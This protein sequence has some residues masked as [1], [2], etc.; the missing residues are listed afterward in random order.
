MKDTPY[1]WTEVEMEIE[2]WKEIRKLQNADPE[3]PLLVHIAS[4]ISRYRNSYQTQME[5][6]TEKIYR[7]TQMDFHG[8][9]I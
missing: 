9:D 8:I 5:T 4:L 3:C 7:E 2:A 1:G 6:V